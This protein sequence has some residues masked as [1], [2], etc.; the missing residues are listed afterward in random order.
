MSILNDLRPPAV[1]GLGLSIARVV[2]TCGSRI[3]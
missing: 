3:R 1:P 2:L